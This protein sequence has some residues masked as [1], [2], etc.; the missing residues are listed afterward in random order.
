MAK[1]YISGREAS[2]WQ[3]ILVGIISFGALVLSIFLGWILLII[4]G[5]VAIIAYVVFRIKMR[6]F[7]KQVSE[8]QSNMQQQ[9]QNSDQ[10]ERYFSKDDNVIDG[11]YKEL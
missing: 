1:I 9:T 11:E 6:K 2:L 4:G 7:Y 5:V 10:S 3:K 8:M